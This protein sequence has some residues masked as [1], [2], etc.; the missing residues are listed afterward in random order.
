MFKFN[1]DLLPDNLNNYSKS[2]K[3]V[4]NYHTRSLE[5]NFSYLDS[6]EKQVINRYLTKKVSY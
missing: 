6:T 3:N 4:H 5:A 2:V 1:N